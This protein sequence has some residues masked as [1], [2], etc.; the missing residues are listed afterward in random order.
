MTGRFVRVLA[1]VALVG[2]P[3]GTA[4]PAAAV[5]PPPVDNRM[6]PR[7]AR[8][9][10]GTDGTVRNMRCGTGCADAAA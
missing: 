1:A 3:V 9:R 8:P 7:R 4:A 6:L 10:R 5:T 2:A